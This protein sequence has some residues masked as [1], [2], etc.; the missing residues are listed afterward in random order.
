MTTTLRLPIIHA[1]LPLR[2]TARDSPVLR[3]PTDLAHWLRLRGELQALQTETVRATLFA[4][5]ACRGR[6]LRPVY[7]I[8]VMHRT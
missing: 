6:E 7:A 1:Y 8:G 3:L 2:L 4:C 5:N